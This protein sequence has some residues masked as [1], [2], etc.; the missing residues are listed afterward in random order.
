MAD[1]MKFHWWDWLPIWRWRLVGTVESADDIPNKLPHRGAVVVAS[2]GLQ[3]WIGFD[4]PCGSGHR[5]MLNLDGNRYP[6]WR[7]VQGASALTLA[8][9]V[10]YKDDRRRCHYFVRAGRTVWCQDVTA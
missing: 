6:A 2:A 10:D 7:V 4:C 9:S 3:K 8:P 1:R 5:I